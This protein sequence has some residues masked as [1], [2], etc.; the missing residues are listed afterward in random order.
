[1]LPATASAR[2]PIGSAEHRAKFPQL[3]KDEH[4]TSEFRLGE[5]ELFWRNHYSWLKDCGYL[6]RPRYSPDWIASWKDDRALASG[7][8][9]RILPPSG[10]VLDATRI[11]DGAYVILKQSDRYDPSAPVTF[12]VFR[13]VFMFHKFSSEPLASDP[14][15]HCIRLGEILHVPDDEE[16]DIIVMPLLFDWGISRFITIGEVVEFFSQIFEGLHFMHSNNVWHGDCKFNSIMM[17]ASP[18]IP[19]GVSVHPLRPEMTRDLSREVRFSNRTE[20]PVKYYWIDFDLSAEHDPS[21]GPALVEP[22]YGGTREVPEFAFEDQLCNP[23]AVDVW[24]LGF[25]IQS[26]FTKK[27]K[28]LEFMN[29]LVADMVHEDPTK[30]PKMGEVVRRFSEIKAGLSEWKLRSRI[31]SEGENSVLGMFRSA[32]HWV[33][34][35]GF[36][37]RRIA[38]IP[39]P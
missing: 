13:E 14:Q 11:S 28:G 17:D 23:F 3:H 5:F 32:G 34:Q 1:M 20:N 35:L 9:D 30:R 25:M 27:K 22:R 36:M 15:N 39:T 16:M 33:R 12:H 18:L 8:E 37:S 2:L 10:T 19:K 29:T 24:C 4:S 21:T 31:V 6:L 7:A 26:Y 38:A